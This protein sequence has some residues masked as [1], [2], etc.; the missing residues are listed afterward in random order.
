MHNWYRPLAAY[1]APIALLEAARALASEPFSPS[2]LLGRLLFTAALLALIS[3]SGLRGPLIIAPIALVSYVLSGSALAAWALLLAWFALLRWLLAWFGSGQPWPSRLLC[4]LALALVGGLGA[5]AAGQVESRFA[6]EELF[7]AAEGLILAAYWGLVAVLGRPSPLASRSLKVRGIRPPG[8]Q[9]SLALLALLLP[10]LATY[11]LLRSYQASFY[12]PSAPGYPGISA[13][14]PFLCGNTAPPAK[15]YQGREV[16]ARLFSLVE[17]SPD[18]SAPQAGMLALGRNDSTW[19]TIFRQRLLSEAAAARFTGPAGSVKYD[20]HE[21]ALRVH[22]FDRMR[23]AFPD[24]FSAA[25]QAALRDWFAA[26]NRRALSAE[27]V[28]WLYGLAF[29]K[30]PEGPYENQ[31]IGAGLLATLEAAGLADPALSPQNRAYLDRAERGWAARFRVTDDTYFYQQEWIT[32]AYLQSRYTG[33]APPAQVRRSVEWLLL[34][35]P[36]DGAALRYNFPYGWSPAGTAYLGAQL[37]GDP[38][39]IWMAG[40][41][42]EGMAARYGFLPPQPGVEQP[43]DL[44]SQGPTVGS[45]LIYGESGLPNQRGP[46][47]PDKI[48][49]RDGWQPDSLYLLLN[50]RFSGWHRYKAT[51]SIALIYQGAPLIADPLD[52]SRLSW[53]P[54]GRSALRDKRLPREQLSGLL[55]ERT[56]LSAALAGLL[57]LGGPWAQDPPFYARVE[58]F[59]TATD[60]DTSVTLIE[61]WRG[62]DQRRTIVLQHGGPLVIIDRASGPPDRQAALAWNL[63]A[64]GQLVGQ[65]IALGANAELAMVPLEPGTL[66]SEPQA[67][68]STGTRLLFLPGARGQ[69]ALASVILPGAWV[70]AALRVEGEALRITTGEREILISLAGT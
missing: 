60:R 12:P 6:D 48:V 24:L 16:F 69:L 9:V 65:R 50:L 64:A 5:V 14:Q 56:G 3:W 51:N 35:L 67:A 21:A 42:A 68:G 55:V 41:A 62:W 1:L 37:T 39:L 34:Q 27:P 31:E 45:C 23:S 58:R 28:D 57:S 63:P 26:I 49:L 32:N 59:S 36:P 2:G 25:D 43:L 11:G 4:H 15:S 53:L 17:R 52:A 61:G 70:G 7:V 20:Q 8:R 47:A 38:R 30:S 13:E 19:A 22:Y 66:R 29:A 46:L 10:T 40:Q 54:E 33:I 44:A 18:Q